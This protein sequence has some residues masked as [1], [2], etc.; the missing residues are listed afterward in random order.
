[1]AES[2]AALL[3]QLH[4]CSHVFLHLLAKLEVPGLELIRHH[5]IDHG[6]TICPGAY[7]IKRISAT[8][9]GAPE[10]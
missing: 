4:D 8:R 3:Q 2:H 1:M 7:V 10:R 6:R 9:G 5:H